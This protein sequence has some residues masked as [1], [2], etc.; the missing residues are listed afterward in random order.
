MS[1]KY[2]YTFTYEASLKKKEK[3]LSLL[4]EESMSLR[5]L[6]DEIC[7]SI[8]HIRSYIQILKGQKLVYINKWKFE[9]NG[10]RWMQ[11]AYFKAGNK[12]DAQK[13]P[14]LTNAERCKR[15]H[16]KRQADPERTQ[17]HN[18]KRRIKRIKPKSD[19]TSEW[20]RASNTT[21]TSQ[22]GA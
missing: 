15:H 21:Q 20:I 13:P 16:K 17:K 12:K 11:M 19:W 2:K 4:S 6:C 8:Q 1:K 3:I 22:D 9:L 10:K 18:I 7:I 14:K 5:Q